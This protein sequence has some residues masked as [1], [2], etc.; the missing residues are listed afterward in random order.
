MKQIAILLLALLCQGITQAQDIEKV[1]LKSPLKFSGSLS[2]NAGLSSISSGVSDRTS[3][4]FYSFNTRFSLSWNEIKMPFYFSFRDHSFN[5]G[6]TVPRFRI[7]PRYKWAELQ[8]G[9][10]FMKFNRYTLSQR[11]LKGAAV[12]LTPGKFRFQALYGKIQELNSYRDTLMLGISDEEVFSNKVIG[13]GLGVGSKSTHIDVYALKTWTDQDLAEFTNTFLPRQDNVV[14]GSTGKLRISRSLRLQYNF[15][16]SALTYDKDAI[17][18]SRTI[19]ENGLTGSLLEVNNS[20]G[21]NYAGDVSINYSQGRFG[22]NGKITYIQPFYQPLTVAYINSD[23]LNYTIGSYVS[24][25]S[26]KLYL[27]GSV[28]IQNNNVSGVDA[29]TTDR[30]IFNLM[31]NAKLHKNLSANLSL[32]NFSQDLQAK[33]VN[34]EDLYTYA[35]TNQMKTLTLTHTLPSSLRTWTNRLSAGNS[36]LSTS[37]DNEEFSSGYDLLFVRWDGD[38][39]ME[40][41]GFSVNAGFNY[42]TYDREGL[43]NDNYGVT[44]GAS[45]DLFEEKLSIQFKN[46]FNY[47]DQGEF[48]EGTSLVTSLV[49]NYKVADKSSLLLS[50]Y[51]VSRKSAVRSDFTEFRSRFSYQQRF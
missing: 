19:A 25:L 13:L 49:G 5:Y 9:D 44:L 22:M 40:P 36:S 20:S 50:I 6:A 33:L 46:T 1:N 51:R 29:F 35:V 17:G 28:G 18:N 47:L 10:V 12:K 34:I 41:I 24:L 11:N 21:A 45:K 39:K 27:N 2:A 31:A 14:I 30:F 48:R 16:L 3:P 26:N 7:N 38:M 23:V 37:N 4:Y 43:V 15:G 32:N 8:V 42:Q